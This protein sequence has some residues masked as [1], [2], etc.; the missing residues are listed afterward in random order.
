MSGYLP[1]QLCKGSALCLGGNGHTQ[2][3]TS[4]DL[5]STHFSPILRPLPTPPPAAVGSWRSW[6]HGCQ[7]AAGGGGGVWPRRDS[8]VLAGG[9]LSKGTSSLA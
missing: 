1:A 8:H 9:S 4:A 5:S 6:A 3:S 7:V 2:E